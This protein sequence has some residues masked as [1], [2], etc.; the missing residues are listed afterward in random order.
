M[1]TFRPKS[2]LIDEM[3]FDPTNETLQ[4][5][6]KRGGSYSYHPVTT[7]IWDTLLSRESAGK[8]FNELVKNVDGITFTKMGE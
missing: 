8:A 3:N 7:E 1:E 4:V 2:S 6:F 5:E